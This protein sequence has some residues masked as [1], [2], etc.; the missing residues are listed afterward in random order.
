MEL[1]EY[2]PLLKFSWTDSYFKIAFCHQLNDQFHFLKK[3]LLVKAVKFFY[4]QDFILILFSL[5]KV[6][7]HGFYLPFLFLGILW[8][9]L[10]LKCNFFKD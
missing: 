6:N 8:T 4:G 5:A 2:F 1:V 3:F 9:D 10:V 7:L